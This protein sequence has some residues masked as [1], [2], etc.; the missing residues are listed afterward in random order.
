MPDEI[1]RHTEYGVKFPDGTV[2]WASELQMF[3]LLVGDLDTEDHRANF[4]FDWERR[5][6]GLGFSHVRA[7]VTFV[8][9]D[10]VESATDPREI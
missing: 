7:H 8:S 1:S 2:K 10:R 9:R 3:G 5:K 6:D 4:G